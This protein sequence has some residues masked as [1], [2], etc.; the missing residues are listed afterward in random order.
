MVARWAHNPKVGGSSPPPATKPI[1]SGIFFPVRFAFIPCTIIPRDM[2]YTKI[3]TDVLNI[4]GYQTRP[5]GKKKEGSKELRSFTS[6]S[7]TQLLK[8]LFQ[9]SDCDRFDRAFYQVTKGKGR[10][11][12]RITRLHSSSLLG[13]LI[14]YNVSKEYP[15]IIKGV[16]FTE[17]FFE[18]E[19]RVFESNSSM[20]VV[21]VSEDKRTLLFLELKF[22]E[23]LNPTSCYWIKEGYFELY[24][25]ITSL[26]D[27]SGI[28]ISDVV[29]REHKHRNQPPTYTREFKMCSK[30]LDNKRQYFG[31]IKQM[32]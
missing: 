2:N 16:K 9:I 17:V 30:S 14:F 25:G 3:Y 10:E 4:S 1:E 20:D 26:L 27:N 24:S 22:T 5:A 15:V 7:K 6:I 23:F 12:R 28:I 11:L 18:V 32:I 19:S 29:K 13:L 21:L 8:N 31:G